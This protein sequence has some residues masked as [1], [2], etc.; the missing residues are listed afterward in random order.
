KGGPVYLDVYAPAA[1]APPIPGAREGVVI[2]PGVG[3]E[4]REPQLINLTEAMARSGVVAM[5][6]TTDTLISYTLAPVDADAVAQAVLRLQR[7]PGVGAGRVGIV[8]F[9]AGGALASL[10]AAEPEMHGRIAFL[11]FFGGYFDA[12][13]LLTDVGRRALIADGKTQ[14]WKPD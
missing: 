10:A 4:R 6:M 14:T 12:E 11:T 7:W 3:D 8:G 1:P 5:L 9:S 2:I 13:S